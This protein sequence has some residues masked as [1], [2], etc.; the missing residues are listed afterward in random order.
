MTAETNPTTPAQ[1]RLG[2][3][4]AVVAAVAL[5]SLAV[6]VAV[7][8]GGDPEVAG[9]FVLTFVAL[10]LLSGASI[11]VAR[12]IHGD[13]PATVDVAAGRATTQRLFG[14]VAVIGLLFTAFP[15]IMTPFPHV[16]A[17][18]IPLVM[19]GVLARG[20]LSKN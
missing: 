10:L 13:D 14:A 19:V 16:L 1:L 11:G 18:A 20:S 4:I 15:A 17:A 2:I 3:A 7:I 6:T 12:L 9:S 5:L 8:G